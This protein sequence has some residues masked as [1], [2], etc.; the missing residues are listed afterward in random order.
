MAVELETVGAVR[1][2]GWPRRFTLVLFF[3]TCAL[4]LYIDRVN[5]S[6]VAPLLMAEFGWDPAVMGTILSAFFVGYLLTQL[7]G[8]W[9]ADRFGGKGILGWAVVWW[10]VA[11][12]VTPFASTV[13]LMI[14]AR[15]GLGI[16]EGVTPPALHSIWWRA[17]FRCTNARASSRLTP[18]GC[19]WASCWPSRS[20]CGW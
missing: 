19:T 20:R 11:T 17:G 2:A 13:P 16:G 12:F 5:I 3:F 1:P 8:G 7:P 15:I 9:L 10:S 18:P 6:V 4:I 14:A